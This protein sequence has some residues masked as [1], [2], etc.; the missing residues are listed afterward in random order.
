MKQPKWNRLTHAEQDLYVKILWEDAYTHEA[1]ANFLGTT[2]GTIVG[3]QQRHPNL[4]A[5]IRKRVDSVVNKERFFDLLEV[6]ELEE[7]AAKRAKRR[8]RS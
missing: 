5:P 7:L 8:G 6:H 4:D 2:K 3:R 1:I